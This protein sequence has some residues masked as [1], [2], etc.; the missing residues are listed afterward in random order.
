MISGQQIILLHSEELFLPHIRVKRQK[1]AAAES[2][3]RD[4][5]LKKH[6]RRL[7]RHLM[8]SRG[9]QHADGV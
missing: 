4:I 8:T 5:L 3:L 6:R 9:V 2:V 7:S 1:A